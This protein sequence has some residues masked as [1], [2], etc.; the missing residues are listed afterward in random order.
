MN[1]ARV[2]AVLLGLAAALPT[3][4][5]DDPVALELQMRQQLAR[6][7]ADV[8]ARF[9][10]ARALAWQ[11]RFDAAL[12]EY[13][14]LLQVQPRNADFLLGTALVHLWRGTPRQAL[15]LL[16][17]ARRLAPRYEDVWRTQIQALLALGDKQA[18][19]QAHLVRDAAR[20]RFPRGNW[21]FAA[22]DGELPQEPAVAVV[23]P[24]ADPAPASSALPDT[25]APPT[26]PTPAEI[27]A[28]AVPAVAPA[29][30][31]P[32]VAPSGFAKSGR[33]EWEAGFT[34]E[35]LSNDLPGWRSRYL[36]GEWHRPDHSVLYGGL[37]GTE[38][39]LRNDQEAHFGGVLPL[40]AQTQLQ[41]E[42]GFSNT[43]RVLAQR[44]GFV[45]AQYQP[46]PGWSVAGGARRSVYETGLSRVL[47]VSVERYIGNERFGYTRYE[48]GPDGSGLAPSHR[49]QWAHSYGARDWIGPA[50]VRGRETEYTGGNNFLTS[51]VRGLSLSG[52]H[53][54]DSDWAML[55]DVGTVRQ[56]DS[57]TRRGVR[58]GLRHAF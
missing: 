48:G 46:A 3:L 29:A 52:R 58:L 25:A 16:R 42:A 40:N 1:S 28:A 6:Q 27:S 55:W 17:Q 54:L 39:Y 47:H 13:A 14:R 23:M 41:A 8:E 49:L 11:R 38:R 7:P 45:Q 51:Q 21:R 26:P 30:V 32:V 36:L 35:R 5:A 37:R 53:D 34:Q 24:P 4:A 19:R 44:Y 12:T 2:L 9:Q 22:L 56:G 10:L 57:Y 33:Y 20:Q 31:P 18:Q 15:P 43:H 50:L